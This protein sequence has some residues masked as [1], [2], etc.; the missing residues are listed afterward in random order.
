MSFRLTVMLLCIA[1]LAWNYHSLDS[2]AR[3]EQ[4]NQ[5]GFE[6]CRAFDKGFSLHR[7]IMPTTG[8]LT[9]RKEFWNLNERRGR[10]TAVTKLR[11]TI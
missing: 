11:T 6:H 1:I 3:N 2:L 5:Q 7:S 4:S 8:E 10:K 9:K